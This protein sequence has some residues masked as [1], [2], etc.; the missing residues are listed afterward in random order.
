MLENRIHTNDYKKLPTNTGFDKFSFFP[1]HQNQG[2]KEK[3]ERQK[4]MRQED[5]AKHNFSVST[6]SNL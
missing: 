1:N 5:E 6:V 2:Q 3:I 4:K